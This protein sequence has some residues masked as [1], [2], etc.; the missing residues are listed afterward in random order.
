MQYLSPSAGVEA[1]F[2]AY[3]KDGIVVIENFYSADQVQ[4]FMK[5]V[6][7]ALEDLSVGG[8]SE[9]AVEAG[10]VHELLSGEKTKRLG[11]L[12]TRSSVFRHEF[13]ENDLM[14]QLLEKVFVERPMDGY[15]MNASELIEITPGSDAQPLHR[16]QELYP[17]WDRAGALMPEAIC[18]FLSAITPFSDINGATRIVPG[19]HL[20]SPIDHILDSNFKNRSDFQTIP[21]TMNS[22][23]C[24]FFSGKILHGGG[25]NQTHEN[26]RGLAISFIRGILT[27][28][29]AHSHTI[30]LEII[31][32]MAY[33]G[34]AMLGFRSQW[35]LTQDMPSIY[36][37]NQGTEVGKYIGL[38]EK[39][40]P[41]TIIT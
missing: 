27:P 14:H 18:N 31:N 22:G 25:A 16:D 17:V 37:A 38:D 41:S 19:T 39:A 21:A 24:I 4:R 20:E 30:P 15:W 13:L 1:I 5:E 12:A 6:E 10:I 9:S 29:I 36:W 28:E 23:D 11:Q 34:Q 26:R 35:P 7:P 40:L 32:T 3:K 8:I 33:R 2:E